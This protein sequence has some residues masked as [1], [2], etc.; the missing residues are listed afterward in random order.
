M[1]GCVKHNHVTP[2]HKLG[3]VEAEF[4]FPLGFKNDY[5]RPLYLTCEIKVIFLLKIKEK[6]VCKKISLL[7]F[8]FLC[9]SLGTMILDSSKSILKIIVKLQAKSLD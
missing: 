5:I 7:N 6:E 4:S 1:V 2:Y 8:A 9:S 3:C